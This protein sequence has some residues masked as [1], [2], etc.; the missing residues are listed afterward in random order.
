MSAINKIGL[1]ANETEKWNNTIEIGI[2]VDCY[3]RLACDSIF[4]IFA[5]FTVFKV[6]C[7]YKRTESA[8][9][10]TLGFFLLAAIS[11]VGYDITE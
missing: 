1:A 8:F 9:L 11:I 5:I 10:F 3:S 6:T 4:G 7:F 2:A